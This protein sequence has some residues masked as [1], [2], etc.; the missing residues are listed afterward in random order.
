MLV[1]YVEAFLSTPEEVF[2]S[3]LSLYT[4]A[5]CRALKLEWRYQELRKSIHSY[6]SEVQQVQMSL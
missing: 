5:T 2:D 1:A 6:P 4:P 3:H